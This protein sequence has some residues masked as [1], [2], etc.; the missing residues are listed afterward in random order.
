[1]DE[2]KLLVIGGVILVTAM[3]GLLI[4]FAPSPRKPTGKTTTTVTK[5]SSTSKTTVPQ[6]STSSPWQ[7]TVSQ[8]GAV[9]PDL[10]K[11]LD[12]ARRIDQEEYE[13]A[14]K[15]SQVWLEHFMTDPG[16]PTY[17]RELYRIRNN[18]AVVDGFAALTNGNLTKA[19]EEF[20]KA[21]SD[22]NSSP[23]IKFFAAKQLLGMS[24]QSRNPEDYFRW[25]KELGA[26]I[27]N[28]NFGYLDEP[29]SN[30]YLEDMKERELYFKAR[31]N[32]GM[33]QKMADFLLQKAP[34]GTKNEEALKEV[35]ARIKRAVLEVLGT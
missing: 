34:Q 20:E 35:K 17:T 1:M 33:Q 5:P 8:A 25:G 9:S 10:L 6:V 29:K 16:V 32:P 19:R 12:E 3:V 23:I 28:E 2:R 21:F 7:A 18:P 14:Q 26:L 15:E 22:P 31:D 13:K 30:R 27:A 24:H 4:L 11:E